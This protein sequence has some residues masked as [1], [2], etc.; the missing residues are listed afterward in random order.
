L[1]KE[2]VMDGNKLPRPRPATEP[3]RDLELTILMG[4][5]D[6]ASD[7]RWVMWN[8]AALD[9]APFTF[10][11]IL[12]RVGLFV[13]DEGKVLAWDH[14]REDYG[15]YTSNLGARWW[16]EAWCWSDSW[17]ESVRQ[18]EDGEETA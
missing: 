18:R 11:S 8:S 4:T 10:V 15:P 9:I 13:I 1:M 16:T 2:R 12:M 14:A 7:R 3:V 17:L 5:I 6:L